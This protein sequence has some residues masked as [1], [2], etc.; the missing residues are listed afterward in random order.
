[1][2]QWNKI[3]EEE[4]KGY[5]YY[6]IL[7]PH[8]DIKK[9]IVWF[10]KNKIR[11]VLDLGCGAGRNL[12]PLAKKSFSLSGLDL[13]PAGFRFIKDSLRKEKLKANLEVGSI[14]KK[15]PYSN[16][17]FDAIISV[18]VLQHG[19][20]KQILKA[21]EEMKRVLRPGGLIFI[22]LCGR[23]SNGKVRLFLVKTAEKVAP[24]TYKPMQGNEKGL[25]HFIY[26]KQ[27]IAKHFKDF[28]MLHSWKDSR[29]YYCFVAKLK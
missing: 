17:S 10:R 28:E 18:Q 4:G 16:S 29:D 11:D 27:R 2:N 7:E 14:Y 6:N 26:N 9:V 21:I 25:T 22:T 23:L 3:Y 1:M 15:L 19:T 20:E 12:I 13:A 8:E 24:N 5:E